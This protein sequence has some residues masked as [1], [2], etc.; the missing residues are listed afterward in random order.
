MAEAPEEPRQ[1]GSAAALAELALCENLSQTSGWAARW[2]A[3]VSG[4]DGALLW[5]P[6]TINP[7]FLCF[8]ADGVEGLE[9]FRRRPAPRAEGLAHDLLRDKKPL[10]LSRK[11]ISSSRDPMLEAMPASVE[12]ALALPLEAEGI[13]VA[14][15]VLVFREAPDSGRVLAR[16]KNFLAQAAPALARAL[17]VERKTIGMLHAIERLTN[18]YDLS[19]AFGAALDRETL[20]PL[21]ARKAADIGVAEAA[22]LWLLAGD[23]DVLLAATSINENYDVENPPESVGAQIVG[24]ALAEGEP[25]VRHGMKE[26]GED[27]YTISSL[28]AIPLFEEEAPVGAIVLANK[29]GRH[30]EFSAEDQEVLQDLGRQAVRA[31]RV[32]RQHEAERK[33]EELDSL[34]SVSREITSTLDLDKVMQAVVNGAAALITFD[35]CAI[36]IRDRGRLRVGAISGTSEI[37]R[38]DPS[39]QRT[40]EILQWVFL[41]GADVNVTEGEDGS[42]SADRPETEEKFRAFFEAQGI[43]AFYGSIL[44]DEEG[45]LGVLGFECQ[46]PVVFDEETQGL[47]GILVNQATV[48]LRNAQL[49]RQVPLAGVLAPL[50]EKRRRFSEMPLKRRRRWLLGIAAAAILLFVVPWRFRLSGPAR[51]L[52]AR[53]A[54]VSSPVGGVV[55]AVDRRE[56]DRLAAGEVIARLDERPY[57]ASLA[58]ARAE[59]EIAGQHASRARQEGDAA[60]L[61]DADNRRQEAA[62]EVATQEQRL[63]WT[64]LTSPVAGVLVTPR[65][66]ERVGRV[67]AGGEEFCV[68]ATA[69][70]K[71][72]AEVAVGERDA[73]YV[74]PGMRA[75]VKFNPFPTRTFHGKVER[76][77]AR[78][79]EENDERYVIAEVLL[80]NPPEELKSG[81]LGRG[82]I[83]AGHRSIAW[84][85]LRRPAGWIY[86][87]LWPLLP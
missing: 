40:E 35:R 55:V 44:K 27:G 3:T 4:A 33:V 12:G 30:P 69:D 52:P 15:L 46:S 17:R 42:I 49:Y 81:M 54:V 76:V 70:G 21:I 13:V 61:F 68:V 45:N 56:G 58:A 1:E 48:A 51:L 84:L 38:K 25:I 60:G 16:L 20:H 34:L 72:I 62:A 47:L 10:F 53:L 6:D 65:L 18:L 14:L 8:A 39:V 2:C 43:K 57:V 64:R 50:A 23:E 82:K 5:A 11:T 31:I 77:G 41:S 59:L 37:D 22:S 78:L 63:T 80:E 86:A 32:V 85:L 29:R 26:T 67:L 24:D 28:L 7:I 87:K 66:E 73:G 19:K 71:I 36:A 83:R 9:K 74:R 79:R 75:E